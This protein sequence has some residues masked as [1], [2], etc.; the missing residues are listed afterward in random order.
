MGYLL[1]I[2]SA[3][4]YA[5]G[6]VAQAVAARRAERRDRLDPGLLARLATDRVYL[7][8]FGAQVVG[9]GLAFLARADLPLYL[10]QAGAMSAV[11]I[12]AVLGSVMFGWQIRRLEIGAL[13]VIAAGLL[14]LVGAAEPSRSTG[15]P[16]V[17]MGTISSPKR[18]SACASA[19]RRWLSTAKASWSARPIW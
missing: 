10:V 16:L 17:W 5:V 18:P 14:L 11:G 15:P 8:G 6:I 19:A 2:G 3:L 7:V 13:V 4:G 9:F 1:L 12:A